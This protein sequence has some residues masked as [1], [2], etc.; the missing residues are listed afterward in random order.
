VTTPDP[1]S[2]ELDEL[3]RAARPIDAAPEEARERLARRIALSVAAPAA[4]AAVV[5]AG[6][7]AKHLLSPLAHKIVIGLASF[8]IGGGVGAGVH[9]LLTRAPAPVV[10]VVPSAPRPELPIAPP[11]TA[12]DIPTVSANDLPLVPAPSAIARAPAPIASVAGLASEQ[13]LL[14]RA[15]AALKRGDPGAA[16]AP[17][18]EHARLFPRGALTE[19]RE[20]LGIQ[21][22]ARS[23][24]L[25]D[26]EER[27]ARFEK[28]FPNS[29]MAPAVQDALRAARGE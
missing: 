21:A 18:D 13:A 10:V 24:R 5:T 16:I 25:A 19:E 20:A 11:P 22:L 26:A 2:P 28:S 29:L 15:R 14:D 6:S 4:A 9:A 23:G 27:A 3:L 12:P 8:A 7:H 1:L 17:L